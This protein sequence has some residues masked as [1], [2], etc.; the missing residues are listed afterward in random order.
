MSIIF[1][2]IT[3]DIKSKIHKKLAEECKLESFWQK[4]L[5]K[6]TGLNHEYISHGLIT[7]LSNDKILIE[8]KTPKLI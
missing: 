5:E 6:L 2:D 1:T 7:D 3:N 4:K 8:I